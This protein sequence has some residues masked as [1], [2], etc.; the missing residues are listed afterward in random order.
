MVYNPNFYFGTTGSG[1][2]VNSLALNN[3]YTISYN[4]DQSQFPYS[5]YPNMWFTI[6]SG[7]TGNV[8][9][10]G[11]GSF[12][13]NST[14]WTYNGG[15]S[16]YNVNTNIMSLTFYLPPENVTITETYSSPIILTPGNYI[17]QAYC[18]NAN[19]SSV[20]NINS[21]DIT[22]N[23]SSPPISN[24]CFP[25]STPITTDQ[26]KICIEQINPDIHTI[27]NKT[28]V[29][30]TKTIYDSD[31]YLVCFEKDSL[32]NNIPSQKT[33]MTQNHKIFY[34]GKMIDAKNFLEKFQN[35]KKVKY[36]NEVLYNVLMEE[37]DEMN[38]NNL[39]CETLNPNHSVAWLY[40]KLSKMDI[41]KQQKLIQSYNDV[42]KKYNNVVRK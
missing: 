34:E 18:A 3:T 8:N 7:K 37:H 29:G 27:G 26:G 15:N 25:A 17:L 13:N 9:I 12:N 6:A 31:K 20:I 39:I 40:K 41:E 23:N 19:Y 10:S 38:V 32:G 2:V 33:V 11:G 16:T 21:V 36:N 4:P 42:Y 14:V 28:I 1:T 24:V 30:I 35:V 22:I 5:T